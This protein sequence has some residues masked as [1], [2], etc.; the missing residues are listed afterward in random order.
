MRFDRAEIALEAKHL[1]RAYGIESNG[2]LDIFSFIN[3]QGIDLIRYPFG[4]NKILGF[5]TFYEGKKIIVSNSSEILSREIYTVAHELG[6]ILY[7]FTEDYGKIKVDRT[8]IE[9]GISEERA[10]YFADCL[11]LPEDKLREMIKETFRKEPGELRAINIVQMQTVFRVSFN[12]LLERMHFTGIITAEQK[13]DLYKEREFYTSKSLFNMLGV[14]DEL[15]RP[16][17]RLVV[18]PRYIDYAMSNYENGYIPLS[19]LKNALNLVN[20]NTSDLKENHYE[21]EEDLLD[22]LFEE[23]E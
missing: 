5:S 21:E 22:E 15:L 13:S 16:T 23:Y 12:A 9:V 14:S 18:P 17:D 3:E 19:S 10:Y 2:I 8:H 4:K 20:I 11:L 6:H 1:R 7:D